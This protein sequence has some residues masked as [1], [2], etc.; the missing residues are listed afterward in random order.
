VDA[1][2]CTSAERQNS[3]VPFFPWRDRDVGCQVI[4]RR[5]W[6]DANAERQSTVAGRYRYFRRETQQLAAITSALY[7]F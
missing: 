5:D 2:Y 1:K 4:P 3:C 7:F 6:L